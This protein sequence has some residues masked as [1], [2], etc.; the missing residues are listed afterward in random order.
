MNH[1]PN[2]YRNV[3]CPWMSQKDIDSAV[4]FCD[5]IWAGLSE[6][7]RYITFR[8]GTVRR[9]DWSWEP[10]PLEYMIDLSDISSLLRS[11][12]LGEAPEEG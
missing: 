9:W 10:H 12:S 3:I 6:P 4:K 7:E 8:I 2:R 1:I 5:R 11:V